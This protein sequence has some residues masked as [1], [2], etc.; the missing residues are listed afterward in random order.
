MKRKLNE[1]D[2][3]FQNVKIKRGF[4]KG[5][6]GFVNEIVG[7]K[8]IGVNLENGKHIYFTKDYLE[9]IK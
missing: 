3:M 5:K 9:I 8:N 4:Y 6:F 2:F 1:E 7:S